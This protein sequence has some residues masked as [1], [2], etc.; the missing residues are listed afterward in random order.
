MKEIIYYPSLS[1]GGCAGDFKKNKEVKPG[2]TCRFYSEEF[3]ERWRHPYFLITAGHHY[4]WPDARQR[5]GLGDDVLVARRRIGPAAQGAHEQGGAPWIAK[6]TP[7]C[8]SS[9]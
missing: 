9:A 8:V 6:T 7:S 3:P 5:Y 1:A 2:L 4:K